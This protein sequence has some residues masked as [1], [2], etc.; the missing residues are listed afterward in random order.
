MLRFH[1]DTHLDEFERM[2]RMLAD[3]LF[4][5][6]SADQIMGYVSVEP[7]GNAVDR[8][9]LLDGAVGVA[10]VLAACSSDRVP[11]WDRMFLLS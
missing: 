9:G 11:T 2:V 8:P 3:H 7:E 6:Y 5:A 10:L 4:G 1:H